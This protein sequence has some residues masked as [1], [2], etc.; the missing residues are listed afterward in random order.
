[1][2]LLGSRSTW[3]TFRD[4]QICSCLCAVC[5][6]ALALPVPEPKNRHIAHVPPTLPIPALVQVLALVQFAH[7][8]PSSRLSR[9]HHPSIPQYLAR[10]P[11]PWISTPSSCCYSGQINPTPASSR[12][13]PPPLLIRPRRTSS[14]SPGDSPPTDRSRRPTTYLTATPS[15]PLLPLLSP[16]P[17]HERQPL[18]PRAQWH[19]SRR[20]SASTRPYRAMFLLP[21]ASFPSPVCICLYCIPPPSNCLS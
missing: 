9:R 17:C 12:A 14:D 5:T 15:C 10:V 19:P 11:C 4:V 18:P 16:L 8:L 20:H 13:R 7:S 21:A 6:F 3:G 2:G 1:M